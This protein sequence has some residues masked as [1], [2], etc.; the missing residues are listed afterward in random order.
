MNDT[1][2]VQ[3]LINTQLRYELLPYPE[4]IKT[5]K[6]KILKLKILRLITIMPVITAIVMTI[7]G[8]S[9]LIRLAGQLTET[10]TAER[11][12]KQE[13][14]VSFRGKSKLSSEYFNYLLEHSREVVDSGEILELGRFEN[15]SNINTLSDREDFGYLITKSGKVHL[16]GPSGKQAL[17]F[18]SPV[19]QPLAASLSLKASLIALADISSIQVFSLLT[20]ERLYQQAKL[21]TRINS[22]DFDQDGSSLLIGATDARVY[23]WKFKQESEEQGFKKKEQALERYVG[24]SAIVSKVLYHP[25][26]RVFFSSDWSGNV[27]AWVRYDADAFEG[28]FITNASSGRPFTAETQ[29][30]RASY[31]AEGAVE[32]IDVS[33][34]GELLAVV[35]DKGELAVLLV[36]GFKS[37]AKIP[38]HQGLIYDMSFRRD[39]KEI[40]TV[41]RDEKVRL[42]KVNDLDLNSIDPT[43]ADIGLIQEWFMPGAQS[44]LFT[45]QGNLM[46]GFKSGQIQIVRRDTVVPL[47]TEET[48]PAQ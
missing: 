34:D 31:L 28:E 43:V 29:R 13:N 4:A 30:V 9:S 11:E 18:S 14:G 39:G 6:L 12:T 41:G 1:L 44:V 33:Q 35:T 23:R 46:V 25:K 48:F 40:I 5:F 36:R 2:T 3:A 21:R 10:N 15:L 42:W 27:S 22:L 38:A 26:G 17:L 47:V 32:D 24:L 7:S 16:I 45:N 19:S 37:L 20:G 8:C